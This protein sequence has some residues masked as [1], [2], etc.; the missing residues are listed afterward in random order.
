MRLHQPV[1]ALLAMWPG[2]WGLYLAPQG[3]NAAQLGITTAIMMVGAFLARSAGCIMNDLADRE[4]DMR[5]ERTRDRPLA[6]GEIT[7]AAARRLMYFLG[8]VAAVLMLLL[9]WQTW[10]F[11]A[12]AACM[13]AIYPYMKRFFAW[14]Q[15]WLGLT[16]S[17]AVPI[18]ALAGHGE[19]GFGVWM[20]YLANTFWTLGYDTIYA[21]QDKKDDAKVG[22]HSTALWA[23]RRVRILVAFGYC[24]AVIGLF[25]GISIGTQGNIM[26][27]GLTGAAGFAAHLLWQM[28]NLDEDKSYLCAML[29][30]QNGLTGMFPAV[31]L[32]AGVL[33]N[34]FL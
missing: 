21:C 34:M 22:I 19:A 17:M 10:I 23:K 29:F 33:A 11:C 15:L 2:L 32:L 18:G 4:I 24:L 20:L 12:L 3:I 14:P 9:P 26:L 8:S 16:F 7:P 30:R 5:V 27:C 1:G 13:A 31:G 6:S 25:A 28:E